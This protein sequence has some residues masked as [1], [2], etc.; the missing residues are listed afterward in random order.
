MR[1]G[2]GL[3]TI[4]PIQFVP[5]PSSLTHFQSHNS[6]GRDPCAI[7]GLLE[8]ACMRRRA[9]SIPPTPTK[10]PAHQY[11]QT[12]FIYGQLA[13]GYIYPG[14]S[15]DDEPH[16][17]CQ[18][19]TV[20]YSL[21]AA[22]TL[23]QNYAPSDPL[24]YALSKSPKSHPTN[25]ERCSRASWVVWS[26]YC[27]AVFVTTSVR[28]PVSLSQLVAYHHMQLPLPDSSQRFN[29]ALGVYRLV[30]KCTRRMDVLH[31]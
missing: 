27:D 14:P 7:G 28:G 29:T 22:C 17:K 30:C 1:G 5:W 12:A 19:N 24:P 13:S 26:Q 21:V 16:K 9:S 6:N 8:S 25:H 3:G 10:L 15:T 18:C 2:V 23:C 4:L 31:A 11:L 20:L